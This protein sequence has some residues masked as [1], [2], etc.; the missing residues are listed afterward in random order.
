MNVPR[1][2]IVGIGEV[3]WDVFPDG[4]HLGGAPANVAI[5][6]AALGANSQMISAVGADARGNA[7]LARLHAAGVGRI[8]VA[9]LHGRPTGVVNIS[10]DANGQPSFD[11]AADAA[12]DHLPWSGAVESVV[13]RADGICFGT[14]AQRSQ[15]SRITIQRALRAARPKAVRLFDVNLRQ[16]YYN[17]DT[18]LASLELASAIKLNDE[19]LPVVARLCQLAAGGAADQLRTLCE[20]FGLSLAAL[21][22]GSRGSLL[23]TA[24]DVVETPAPLTR[25]RDTVGAG[26]AFTAALLVGLLRHR[27]LAEIGER[28][29]AIAAYVCSQPGATP[30]IP[31]EL[32]R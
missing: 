20:R 11:I 31:A 17:A 6:A 32:S 13:E 27:T 28:A 16:R 18:I 25:I 30:P 15:T 4:E 8:A 29:N 1:P 5:H 7:A 23:V 19:E 9:Q 12:W 26:D 22:R 24:A 3:L 2:I 21:T 10:I 14:L